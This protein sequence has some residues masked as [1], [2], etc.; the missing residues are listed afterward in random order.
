MW[1]LALCITLVVNGV[2]IFEMIVTKFYVTFQQVVIFQSLFN[3]EL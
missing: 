2:H 3:L 1:N